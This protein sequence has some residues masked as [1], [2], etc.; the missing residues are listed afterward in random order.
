MRNFL[1]VI[2]IC[3]FSLLKGQNII[4]NGSF[5]GQLPFYDRVPTHWT[6][7]DEESSPDIQPISSDRLAIDGGTYL[8]LVA[9][10]RTP[11]NLALTGS[12]EAINQEFPDTLV[13]GH[14]YH[15]QLYL[16]Y[17]PNHKPSVPAIVG[18][19]YT[20]ISLGNDRCGEYRFLW[21]S[22]LID[23]ESWR[24]Y[25]IVFTALC[26]DKFLKIESEIGDDAHALNYIMF[27]N[28]SLEKVSEGSEPLIDCEDYYLNHD[29]YS[30]NV[31]EI[32][33]D[34][35]IYLPNIFSPNQDGV[36][37]IFKA[38]T[39]CN[40]YNPFLK[41]I[42]RWGNTVYQSK[43]INEGWD[44]KFNGEDTKADIYVVLFKYDYL[45]NN[46]KLKQG[47]KSDNITLIR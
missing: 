44:G 19:A 30:T 11:G 40:I 12:V 41:I 6:I 4:Q 14:E 8:G 47:L 5:E 24:R 37:D 25:D 36:N 35:K 17:D 7:C 27:D 23:H 34:C 42:D 33:K 3:L 21:K 1:T 13:P 45:D 22:P 28:I 20:R 15:L 9:R 29:D 39:S 2:I 31:N 16:M 18:P 32:N 46:G 10:V 43:D 26:G 38:E